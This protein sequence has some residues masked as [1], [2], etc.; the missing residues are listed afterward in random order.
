MKGSNGIS[1]PQLRVRTEHSFRRAYGPTA[2]VAD[3]LSEIGTPFAGCVDTAGTWGHVAWEKELL[4]RGLEPGFGAEFAVPDEDGGKPVAWALAED[5]RAFYRFASSAPS[6]VEDFAAARGVV[7]FAGDALSDPEA[8]DYVDVNPSSLLAAERALSLAKATG[9]PLVLTGLNEYPAEDD[10]GAFMAWVDNRRMT[11]QHILR[12]EDWREAFWFLGD[13]V[14]EE[15]ARNTREV[16]ERLTGARL[17]QAPLIEVPDAHERLLQLVRDGK[18]YRI[19]AGHIAQW[20]S[21]YEERVER[22]LMLI[23]EKGFESYFVV[24]QDLVRWAKQHMLV[25]PA[26]GSSAGSLVCYLLRITEV[27]PLP[28]GL[29]FERFIDINRSDLPDIDIDFN[30]KKRHLCFEYLAEAY[31]SENVAR[32]GSVSTL[33]PRSVINQVAKKMA[34]PIGATF[35]VVNVLVDYSSGDSRYGHE[36]EDTLKLTQPGQQFKERYPEAMVMGELENHA[37]HSGVH[38][39]GIIVSTRPVIDYCTVRDG[40]AQIDKKGAEYLNLLKIDAL[41]LRTLGVIEDAGCITPEALYGLDLNDQAVFDVIND[42]KFSGIFQFEGSAQRS[43]SGSVPIDSFKKIDHITALARPGPLGGGASDKYI[44]RNLGKEPVTYRHPSMKEYLSDT[45]G[46][47]LYQEQVMRIS[48]EIGRFSW[49]VVS[50]IRKAMSGSKGEEYFNR[51]GDEFIAGA[52]T[53]GIPK[54]EAADI[55]N[56]ICSF[57]SWGMNKSHTTS[58]AVISYWCAYM[59]KNYPLEYAAACLRNAK[60]DEQTVEILREL[61]SE[62]VEYVPFDPD[63]SEANWAAKSGKLVGGFNN[64]I[65]IGPIKA[66]RYIRKREQEGLGEKDRAAL[67]KLHSKHEDLRPAHTLWGD[68]YADPDAHNIRSPVK[69]F[70]ALEDREEAVIICRLI[71]KERR[72]ENEALRVGRR[73]GRRWR[74][75]SLFLDC[76]VV[77]DSVSKPVRLRVKIPLWESVGRHIADK[78]VDGADWFLVRGVWLSMFSMFS[79]EKV[80]CLTNPELFE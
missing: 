6:T 25:G 78:A 57:G 36:L 54:K 51:R 40:I 17:Q 21:F 28:Y 42:K 61:S 24:V 76:F 10:W 35:P 32:I 79:A 3:V 26:R 70:G 22:E 45:M 67:A 27:D 14:F 7:R 62:G 74:G 56:E 80:K 46:V 31:G 50:E 9:K 66:E 30:D 73:N 60:D 69:E 29:L 38:A 63:L 11:P 55:W 33:R 48:Y 1:L 71:K 5:T 8:F 68:I 49:E 64:L 47:V 34:I 12:P 37:S 41:G 59:K 2:R 19:E 52:A 4:K 39:A 44:A 72:D 15:A 13:D 58:Y 75:P 18:R 43:V 53:L 65:G 23:A 16:G 77:D 20:D